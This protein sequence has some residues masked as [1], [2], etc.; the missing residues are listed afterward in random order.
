M[1]V[2]YKFDSRCWLAM[3]VEYNIDECDANIDFLHPLDPRKSLSRSAVSDTLYPSNILC[4]INTKI[5]GH[6]CHYF[7]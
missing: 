6:A 5:V 7:K 4:T 1:Y 2:T 3:I